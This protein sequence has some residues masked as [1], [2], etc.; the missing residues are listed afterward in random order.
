[1]SYIELALAGFKVIQQKL[2]GR[3]TSKGVGTELEDRS[4]LRGWHLVPRTKFDRLE[5]L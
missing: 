3:R 1:M 4:N 5:S 2:Q